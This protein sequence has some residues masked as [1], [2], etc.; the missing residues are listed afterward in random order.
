MIILVNRMTQHWYSDGLRFSCTGCGGC[1][2]GEPGYVWVN[3]AEIKALADALGL[4]VEEFERQCV[5]TVG[6]RKSL[7]ER[8]NGDCVLFDAKTRKC[9]VYDA[10]PRQCRTWPFW[11][12]NLASPAAWKETAEHCPGCNRGRLVSYRAIRET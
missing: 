8:A 6:I 9:R 1:C 12:S 3:R 4:R 7:I 10:R 11:A 2:T 5:R